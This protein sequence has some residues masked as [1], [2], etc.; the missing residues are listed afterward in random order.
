MP[1]TPDNPELE[2]GRDPSKDT[3]APPRRAA[4]RLHLP[5]LVTAAAA[6]NLGALASL[7]AAPARWPVAATVVAGTHLLLGAAGFFPRNGLLGPNLTRIAA[8][9]AARSF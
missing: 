2:G 6:A 7:A 5:P 4:R 3:A 9:E 1:E 8:A